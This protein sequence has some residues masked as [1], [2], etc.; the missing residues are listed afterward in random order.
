MSSR[1]LSDDPT[2]PKIG[3]LIDER[4]YVQR[5][6][7]EGGFACVYQ[8]HDTQAGGALAIKVLHASKSHD[9]TFADRFRHE[10]LLVRQLQHP[11]TI[12]IWDSGT[13]RTGCL[14]MAMEYAQGAP[15]DLLLDTEG[16]LSP[17]R[18]I[19]ITRQILKSLAE[20]HQMG[21]VH[22]DLKPANIV[23]C[24][25]AGESDFVKVLDFG[26]AK[27]LEGELA[28][29]KTQTGHVFC[30]PKYAAPEILT[31]KGITPAAD[32]YAMGLIIAEMLTGEPLM[33]ADSDA[34]IIA[35]QLSPES[36]VMPPEVAA[37]PL[38][39]VIGYATQKTIEHRYT[40]AEHM[41]QAIEQVA[42]R[43]GT[44]GYAASGHAAPGQQWNHGTTT[45]RHGSQGHAPTTQAGASG[46]ATRKLA[47]A[48]VLLA[49]IAVL[50]VGAA[51]IITGGSNDDGGDVTQADAGSEIAQ[52]P[53]A[54]D[55][56]DA[57]ERAVQTPDPLTVDTGG[58][59]PGGWLGSVAEPLPTEPTAGSDSSPDGELAD[60]EARV[61]PRERTAR[62]DA[63]PRT[64]EETTAERQLRLYSSV[65][66]TQEALEMLQGALDGGQIPPEHQ[67]AVWTDLV[68]LHVNVIGTLL[69]LGLCDAARSRVERATGEASRIGANPGPLT[70]VLSSIDLC[71]D[72]A[73][74]SREEWDPASYLSRL[75]QAQALDD[76][77]NALPIED[78]AGRRGLL[79]QSLHLRQTSRGM[80]EGALQ[81]GG[82]PE[83]QRGQAAEDLFRLSQVIVANLMAL[84]LRVAAEAQLDQTLSQAA[85]L[86][87]ES[88]VL[89]QELKTQVEARATPAV[90]DY[91]RYASLVSAGQTEFQEARDIEPAPEPEPTTFVRDVRITSEPSRATVYRD[92][93]RLGRTPFEAQLESEVPSLT[94]TLRKTDHDS[95]R[96]TIDLSVGE[97]VIRRNVELERDVVF[98]ETRRLGDDEGD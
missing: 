91:N 15:L 11:N 98:G 70:A 6:L 1:S 90:W 24:Q 72:H 5:L 49:G 94:L 36:A 22:R 63:P 84:E 37:G 51:F 73:Q 4:Y 45:Q 13:T 55:A 25:I 62:S 74:E 52:G 85:V 88:L 28:T 50:G 20:A 95:E 78:V 54:E 86:S 21:I 79:Y 47:L 57:S 67:Q 68:Q 89:L 66:S 18:T 7:G 9:P 33:K 64:R 76:Q 56:G 8:A 96:V 93:E 39:E 3:E 34:E 35:R 27:A 14:F 60:G 19:H 16:G 80:L 31:G 48:L 41:L 42:Q 97:G 12:K 61:E 46:S 82:I 43:L 2:M 53:G 65:Q 40:G 92:G 77:A 58:W 30:T 59:E 29:V 71:F 38:A 17:Q 83:E 69:E 75:E 87:P 23:I 10:I 44:G 32:V 26:I 81:G